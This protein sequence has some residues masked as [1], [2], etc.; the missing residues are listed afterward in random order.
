MRGN[1]EGSSGDSNPDSSVG[2]LS[3]IAEEEESQED[4]N[5]KLLAHLSLEE[6]EN[7]EAV[8]LQRERQLP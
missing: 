1:Y 4:E 5:F 2:Q 3:V 8:Q 6:T 7:P